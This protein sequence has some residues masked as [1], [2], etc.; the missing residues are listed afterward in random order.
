[1]TV[2]LELAALKR[3]WIE[4]AK[5]SF[6]SAVLPEVWTV[7][8]LRFWTRQPDHPNW[9]GCLAA[10]LKNQGLIE[11]VG[12]QPSTRPAANGRVVAVWRRT[13]QD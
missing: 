11:R 3:D 6:K 4:D 1:M 5:R 9:W 12:Y 13:R 2:Q 10:S 7:D 8:E